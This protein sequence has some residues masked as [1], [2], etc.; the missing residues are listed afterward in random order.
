MCDK[1][2][3]KSRC[4][5][6]D[7]NYCSKKC[8]KRA[9]PAHKKSCVI[10]LQEEADK[11]AAN[12]MM[13]P[14]AR[15]L[16]QIAQQHDIRARRE[17]ARACY[18][19][20][21]KIFESLGTKG[22]KYSATIM[23]RLANLYSFENKYEEAIEMHTKALNTSLR[24]PGCVAKFDA[25]QG[26]ADIAGALGDTAKVKKTFHTIPTVLKQD[27]LTNQPSAVSKGMQHDGEGIRGT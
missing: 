7:E 24:N 2:N 8:Q 10:H 16:L 20:A 19:A 26:M 17:D 23:N 6:K 4:P 18:T 13:I 12:G 9:W 21:L 14:H 1:E 27:G 15:K 25:Y 3:A 11:L 5:C 22:D